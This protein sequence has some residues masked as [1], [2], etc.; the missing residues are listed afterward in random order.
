MPA[1]PVPRQPCS[2]FEPGAAAGGTLPYLPGTRRRGGDAALPLGEQ[3][4][5]DR[6]AGRE[7]AMPAGVEG[8]LGRA[9]RADYPRRPSWEDDRLI[10]AYRSP[11][12]EQ[13]REAGV[14]DVPGRA[15][16]ARRPMVARAPR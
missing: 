12:G 4:A 10:Q 15:P 3:V 16:G 1:R 14:R 7:A 5:G 6:W 2:V 13:V 11:D 8:A 9:R